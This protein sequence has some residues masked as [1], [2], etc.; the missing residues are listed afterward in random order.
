MSRCPTFEN[1]DESLDESTNVQTDRLP[2]LSRR[3]FGSGRIL[4]TVLGNPWGPWFRI[5]LYY[6]GVIVPAVAFAA[7]NTNEVLRDQGVPR[8]Q[9]GL[10]TDKFAFAATNEAIWP[11]YLLMIASSVCLTLMLFDEARFARQSVVVFGLF[12]GLIISFWFHLVLTSRFSLIG[13]VGYHVTLMV[14]IGLLFVIPRGFAWLN[15][16]GISTLQILLVAYHLCLLGALIAAISGMEEAMIVFVTWPV[17]FL[18]GPYI[19][20]PLVCMW[21]YSFVLARV[22]ILYPPTRRYAL[23]SLVLVWLPWFAAFFASIRFSIVKSL[24]IYSALPVEEPTNCFIVSAAA[25][26]HVDVVRST[27]VALRSGGVRLVNRQLRVF[28]AFEIAMSAACPWLHLRLRFFYNTVGP[29]IASRISNPWLADGVYILLKPIEWLVTIV[30]W[31]V[32]GTEF[33]FVERLYRPLEKTNEN[34]QS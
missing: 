8:Y 33:R 11:F 15:R 25:N 2:R 6:S 18:I 19:F 24:E 16:R 3:L 12:S 28:K 4:Q 26:G 5:W 27:T 31:S 29:A 9:T 21:A 14:F 7:L 20:A 22:L 10:T 17:V 32:L 23:K 30:L 34:W 1:K 13:S